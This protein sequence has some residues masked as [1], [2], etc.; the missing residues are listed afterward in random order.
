MNRRYFLNAIAGS[1]ALAGCARKPDADETGAPPAVDKSAEAEIGYA[2]EL[3][4]S[5]TAVRVKEDRRFHSGDRFRFLFRPGFDAHVYLVNR[6]PGQASYQV[7]FPS[8]RIAVRNPIA[9]GKSVTVPDP[10][11]GWLR[12]DA[13]HGEENLILIA[14]TAPLE[15]FSGI[16]ADVGRDEFESK[17]AAVERR[18]R[19]NSSRRFEDGD[20]VKLFAARGRQDLA[21][22]V[23]LPLLHG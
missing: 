8:D 6:G 19:P 11:T 23:R 9:S 17:L 5:G 16:G 21:I 7:L 13:S 14:A 22:V 2:I 18:Y 10:D 4:D 12:M 15:E 20:W 1:L 3:E